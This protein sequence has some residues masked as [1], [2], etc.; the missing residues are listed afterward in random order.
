MGSPYD[1]ELH[2]RVL[3]AERER[4][5]RR[6]ADLAWQEVAAPRDGAIR[7]GLRIVSVWSIHAALRMARAFVACIRNIRAGVTSCD[8]RPRSVLEKGPP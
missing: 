8:F 4:E 3:I 6:I 5:V 7:P 2:A 1:A